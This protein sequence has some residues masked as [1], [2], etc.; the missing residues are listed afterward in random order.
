MTNLERVGLIQVTT[1][2][3]THQLCVSELRK[4]MEWLKMSLVINLKSIWLLIG[5]PLNE[6]IKQTSKSGNWNRMHSIWDSFLQF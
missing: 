3:P 2:T 5:V 6:Q 4:R 1:K